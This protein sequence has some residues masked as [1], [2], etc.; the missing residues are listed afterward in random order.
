[1]TFGPFEQLPRFQ[2]YGDSRFVASCPTARHSK[3]DRHAS[4][5]GKL[6]GQKILIHC[7]A[8]CTAKEILDA[9]GLDWSALFL[10][11]WEAPTA[12]RIRRQA[13]LEGFYEWRKRATL[14]AARELRDRDGL[15]LTAA[16]ALGLGNVTEREFFEI[17]A[18]AYRGYSLLEHE[19][20]IL[21]T[22]TD[23]QSLEVYQNGR[24]Q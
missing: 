17:P 19:F 10:D 16:T 2:T 22:G 3:G 6:A 15:V 4:F 21:R 13:A 12:A 24:Y 5:S 1:M 11:R 8:G 18:V 20:E 9:M 7:K 14:S 23:A